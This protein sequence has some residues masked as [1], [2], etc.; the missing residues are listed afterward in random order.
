M[1]EPDRSGAPNTLH[2]WF[3]RDDDWAGSVEWLYDDLLPTTGVCIMAGPS[4]S[5]KTFAALD[6]AESLALQRPFFGTS[7]EQPG[8]VLILAGEAF[9]S[10]KMRMQALQKGLPVS[11]TYVGGL[12]A[13][14]AWAELVGRLEAKAAEMDLRFGMPVRLIILDTLS[15]SGILAD[16][17]N[18]AEAA[19]VMKAFAELSARMK[20]LFLILHHPPKSGDGERGAGAIRNNADYVMSIRREG[21]SAVREI[22]M[23]KSRDAETKVFGTFTLEPVTIGADAKGK[24]IKTMRIS[25]GLPRVRETRAGQAHA[26]AVI[27]AVEFALVQNTVLVEGES[28]TPEREV[29]DT[30]IQFWK[31]SK[32]STGAIMRQFNAA[33]RYVIDMG[34][35]DALKHDNT[36]YYKRKEL[37]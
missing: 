1:P 30:F 17:N 23:T 37:L 33:M 26:E 8:S 15:S 16:E 12:A 29:A 34:S 27:Q 35:V 20:A 21:T 10:M 2:G 32:T 28:W 25:A 5:G 36:V 18:N 9:G 4:N 6:L 13:R 11:A 24:E 19:T 22:E 3:D 31:G 7:P 14:G